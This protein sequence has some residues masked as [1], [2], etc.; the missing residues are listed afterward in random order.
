LTVSTDGTSDFLGILQQ[1]QYKSTMKVISK[2]R[3]PTPTPT[4]NAIFYLFWDV[5][6]VVSAVPDYESVGQLV[7]IRQTVEIDIG[8]T[9]KIY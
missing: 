9:L 6:T 7:V 3:D 2:I 1:Q 4:P 5:V 8:P